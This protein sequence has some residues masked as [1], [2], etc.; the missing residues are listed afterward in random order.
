MRQGSTADC[1]TCGWVQGKIVHTWVLERSGYSVAV[2]EASHTTSDVFVIPRTAVYGTMG[3]QS[4][5]VDNLGVQKEKRK[6]EVGR[7][8]LTFFIRI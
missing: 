6:K 4:P 2:R 8:P 5:L 3:L 1:C 7:P